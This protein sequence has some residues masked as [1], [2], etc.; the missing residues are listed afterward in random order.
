MSLPN[1]EVE[2]TKE[3]RVFDAA[4]VEAILDASQSMT[5]LLVMS[6]GWNN[7][8]G[9]ARKLYDD[10]TAS[11]LAVAGD[12]PGIEERKLAVLRV[13]WPS[14]RFADKDLISGGGVALAS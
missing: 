6:H 8:M 2:F 9:E 14:K 5:D 4:Q 11:I 10:L 7:D 1:F 13:F 3:G 12:V